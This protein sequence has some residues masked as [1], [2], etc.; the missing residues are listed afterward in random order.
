MHEMMHKIISHTYIYRDGVYY[1]VGLVREDIQ[2]Y[3]SSDRIPMSLETK[4]LATANRAMKS[5]NQAPCC[6]LA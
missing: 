4:L 6:N 5:I 2:S 1:F 3:Y